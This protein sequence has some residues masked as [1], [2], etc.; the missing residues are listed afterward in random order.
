[1]DT[2]SNAIFVWLGKKATKQEKTAAFENGRA[3]I[4]TKGYKQWCNVTTVKEGT[5]TPLFKQNFSNW[6]NKG[7]TTSIVK[8]KRA[9]GREWVYGRLI[10]VTLCVLNMSSSFKILVILTL[11]LSHPHSSPSKV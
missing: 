1:M 7:E 9:P 10:V 6:L 2:G 3:F 11:T 5:E 4:Q 8:P